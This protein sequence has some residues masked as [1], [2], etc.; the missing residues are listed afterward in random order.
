MDVQHPVTGFIMAFITEIRPFWEGSASQ[1]IF[2]YSSLLALPINIVTGKTCD[3]PL[4][5]G[6]L[7]RNFGLFFPG[8]LNID[9]MDIIFRRMAFA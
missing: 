7:S 3:F 2:V 5:Q 8:E 1:R 9:R 4:L 6:K